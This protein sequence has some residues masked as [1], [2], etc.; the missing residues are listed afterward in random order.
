MTTKPPSL[1]CRCG[2]AFVS[3]GPE[4]ETTGGYVSLKRHEHNDNC[5]TRVY[6]C[7]DGHQT[8]IGRRRRCPECGWVGK[9]TCGCHPG[10]KV[11]VWPDVANLA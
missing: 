10:E 3:A 11:D 9:A 7:L 2:A 5:L 4:I 8:V 1:R 6:R